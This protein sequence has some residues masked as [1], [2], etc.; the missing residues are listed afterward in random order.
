MNVVIQQKYSIR[1]KP[2]LPGYSRERFENFLIGFIAIR[3]DSF[4]DSPGIFN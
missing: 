2:W 1:R 4:H 3:D